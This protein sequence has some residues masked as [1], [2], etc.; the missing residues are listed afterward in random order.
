MQVIVEEPSSQ[1][2]VSKTSITRHASLARSPPPPQ[3][4]DWVKHR[5]RKSLSVPDLRRLRKEWQLYEQVDDLNPLGVKT[6]QVDVLN[7]RWIHPLHNPKI[8]IRLGSSQYTT[9]RGKTP[10]GD[11]N[12]GFRFTISY[13]AQ[14]FD[15]I[16]FDLFDKKHQWS[17]LPAQ[18]LGKAKLKLA[19]LAQRDPVFITFVPMYEYRARRSLPADVREALMHTN[20]ARVRQMADTITQHVQLWGSL[21]IRVRYRFQQPE[22][23]LTPKV[24]RP[25]LSISEPESSNAGASYKPTTIKEDDTNESPPARHVSDCTISPVVS[26]TNTDRKRKSSATSRPRRSSQHGRG[27]LARNESFVDSIFQNNLNAVMTTD[28]PSSTSSEGDYGEGDD[29]NRRDEK[30]AETSKSSKPSNSRSNRLVCP[31][32]EA[33]QGQS[34]QEALQTKG[35]RHWW[36]VLLWPRKDR[37]KHKSKVE[38]SKRGKRYGF[39]QNDNEES[40]GIIPHEEEE[41]AEEEDSK[42]PEKGKMRKRDRLKQGAQRKAQHIIYS[43]NFGDKNFASQWMED[44]FDDVAIS[45]PLIDHLIGLVVSRQTQALVRAIIKLANAFGQGFRVTGLRLVKAMII[46]QRFYET[47]PNTDDSPL[48]R[49]RILIPESCHY[50]DYAMIAYGWRGLCYLGAYGQYV[51]G[52]R[53]RRSNRMSIIRYLHLHP[54]DLLGYEYG[55]RKGA[56]FQPS[57]FVAIDRSKKAIVLSIRGT[58]SLYDAITDLVCTYKPW[59]GG[60]VHSGMLAS[61]QWFYTNIVPQIF[62]YVHHHRHNITAFHIVGHSLGGGTASLLTMM[63]ADHIDELRHL[64][65]NPSFRLHCYSYA[66][67]A[68][69]SF[70]LSMRYNDYIHSFIVQDDVVGRLSYGTAMKLK[71]LIMDTISAYEALGGWLKVLRDPDV[72]KVCFNILSKRREQIYQSDPSYPLLY[73]PGHIVHIQRTKES[74]FLDHR[75]ASVATL[76]KQDQEERQPTFDRPR[77]ASLAK[78]IPNKRTHYTAHMTSSDISQEMYLSNSCI[79]DHMISSYQHAFKQLRANYPLP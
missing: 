4:R 34:A 17:P 52:I 18:H 69:S 55:L 32:K 31:S 38:P 35:R 7:I 30:R 63:V 79:E 19:T 47:L 24:R 64:A 14:L 5:L 45:H 59:K 77:S 58:W 6:M 53:N 65:R 8:R 16:E 46:L 21:Q 49:N 13:H 25:L 76:L 11:W 22:D 57:Y 29:R 51:R 54:E 39:S 26:N 56:V 12:E 2:G 60:L 23:T 44:S 68:S 1:P 10:T 9:V 20:M 72:R 50:F 36:R 78:K 66:P 48:I 33:K 3:F 42:S 71:E 67:V 43:V 70:D 28:V 40:Y 15:T 74:H 75:R 62:R 61:A 41:E 37:K 73:I 27:D